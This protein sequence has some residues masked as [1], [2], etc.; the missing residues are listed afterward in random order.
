MPDNF[1]VTGGAGFI[2]SNIVHQL[3]KEGE[4]VRVIDNLSTGTINNLA[5][6][7]NN[8]DFIEGDIRDMATLQKA[9]HDIDYVLHQAALPSVPRSIESPTQCHE[10]NITGT[11]NVLIA[12]RENH[13]KR[14]VFASSSS[15]YGDTSILHKKEEISPSPLSPY[16]LTKL[17]GE[18]YCKIFY[19][20]YGLE[21]ISLRYFN[22]F[23]PHQ[24]PHSEYAAVIPRFIHSLLQ[25]EP[26]VIY[27]D[28]EQ[29][30]DFT[31]IENVV[32]ANMLAARV[33]K[34]Q[35]EVVNIATGYRTSLNQL[36]DQLRD[37]TNIYLS[38]KYTFSRKGDVRH[39][40]ADISLATQLLDYKPTIHL[41]DGLEQTVEWFKR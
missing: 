27:G 24:N 13:V 6:V 8:I 15:V 32:M 14:F 21:T 35:G 41:K 39:S 1:L 31:F 29:T 2:G 17:T 26:P 36:L 9:L 34:T 4:N 23:G 11:L 20:V 10:N 37:I 5:P 18:F 3:V 19:T 12:A 22:V 25:N 16:A 38:P 7:F 33:K 40:L 28:G 30:R